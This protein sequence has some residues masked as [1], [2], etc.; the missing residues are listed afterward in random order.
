MRILPVA[1]LLL[2]LT[3][4]GVTVSQTATERPGMER[5]SHLVA[6]VKLLSTSYCSLHYQ[7]YGM[8]RFHLRAKIENRGEQAVILCPR[9]VAFGTAVFRYL[10]PD[11]TPGEI[12]GPILPDTF[13]YVDPNYPTNLRRAYAILEPH[14]T[15]EFYGHTG[16]L[17][18]S[19]QAQRGDHVTYLLQLPI[20]TWNGPREA[21]ASLRDRWKSVAD[22]FSGTL[23]SNQI[24][25]DIAPPKTALPDCPP[26]G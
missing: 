20:H 12:A 1:R 4:P 17:F 23:T 14:S 21:A 18:T 8:T 11:G 22:L 9:Y 15:F 16:I 24:K 2:C 5:E 19:A 26:G 3:L 13:G 25:V 10:R 7:S 6:T